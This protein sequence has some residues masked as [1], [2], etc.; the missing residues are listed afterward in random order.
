MKLA[1]DIGG[2]FTDLVYR[3]EAS[4]DLGLAKAPSTPSDLERGVMEASATSGLAAIS[5]NA[6]LK[7]AP[8]RSSRRSPRS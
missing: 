4:G 2:T 5:P 6:R 7:R 3:D 1:T 8:S